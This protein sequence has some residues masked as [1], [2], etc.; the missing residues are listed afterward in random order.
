MKH[1]ALL[2]TFRALLLVEVLVHLRVY[3]LA[4]QPQ[5]VWRAVALFRCMACPHLTLL[6]GTCGMRA[7]AAV[8]ALLLMLCVTKFIQVYI[9]FLTAEFNDNL[10]SKPFIKFKMLSM[11]LLLT[12]IKIRC[13][14]RAMRLLSI[15]S[16]LNKQV[17]AQSY[18][19]SCGTQRV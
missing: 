4:L 18:L 16:N 5:K 12:K 17:F 1:T 8:C 2:I 19:K 9:H 14:F 3:V 7:F 13:F 15:V 11:H 6:P 10:L